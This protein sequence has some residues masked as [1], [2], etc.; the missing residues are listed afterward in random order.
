[1]QSSHFADELLSGAEVEVIGVREED[2]H[3]EI[4]GQCSLGESFD[5]GLSAYRHEDRC[6]D[7]SVVR[8][9]ASGA[10]VGMGAL[11]LELEERLGQ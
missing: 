7:G 11:R 6:L 5:R 8:V 9:E 3:A 2:L 4:F 10:G 1:M